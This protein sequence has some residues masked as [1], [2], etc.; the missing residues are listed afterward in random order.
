MCCGFR[1]TKP[2]K[3]CPSPWLTTSTSERR[4][5]M[6]TDPPQPPTFG[7][8]DTHTVGR[9]YYRSVVPVLVITWVLLSCNTLQ[10][11]ILPCQGGKLESPPLGERKEGIIRSN[12]RNNTESS[13]CR[14]MNRRRE[15]KSLYKRTVS[16]I[17]L[18]VVSIWATAISGSLVELEPAS[19]PAREQREEGTTR[20]NERVVF[21]RH[22]LQI[23]FYCNKGTS[24]CSMT[25]YSS[26]FNF[27]FCSRQW[28]CAKYDRRDSLPGISIY[29]LHRRH[30]NNSGCC[31]K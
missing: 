8:V 28:P 20:C 17:Q 18:E 4:D 27:C 2:A 5:T 26:W 23:E 10:G 29:L 21:I 13:E 16:P 9:D 14:N 30:S 1:A 15:T 3:Y 12:S 19:Q 11:F 22:K 25:L 7:W 6:C 31:F 24:L